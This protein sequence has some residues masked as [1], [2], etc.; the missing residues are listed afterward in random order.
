MRATV[1]GC[2]RWGS[3]IAWYLNELGH[4]VTLYGRTNSAHMN[5]FLSARSNG[6][7]TLH[8]D[9]VLSTRLEDAVSDADLIVISI[10]SQALRG[11]LRESG[12]CLWG[13]PLVLCM[14][15]LVVGTGKR[16]TE[17]VTDTLGEDTAVAVWLGPGH[18]QEFINRVPGLL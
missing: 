1:I 3:F 5:A 9:I 8:E 2:G 15:W 7:V 17:I 18:V 11:M 10:A 4:S 16:L 12:K 14:K 6:L 13:K